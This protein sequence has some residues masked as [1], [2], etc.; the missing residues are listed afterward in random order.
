MG[1]GVRWQILTGTKATI[2]CLAHYTHFFGMLLNKTQVGVWNLGAR[3][4][5]ITTKEHR[6]NVIGLGLPS[7]VSDLHKISESALFPKRP[8]P[9][10]AAEGV[11]CTAKSRSC[12]SRVGASLGGHTLLPRCHAISWRAGLSSPPTRR[13]SSGSRIGMLSA[14]AVTFAL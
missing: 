12:P 10:Y 14:T 3:I 5:Y 2:V 1:R 11:S 13:K 7:F 4:M 8:V 6:P 9:P